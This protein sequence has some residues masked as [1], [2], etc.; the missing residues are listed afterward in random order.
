MGKQSTR[1]NKTIYQLC[2]EA[3]GLTRDQAAEKMK[4]LSV[5]R[6]EK[7]EYE[8]TVPD[9]YDVVE[10]A[11][12]YKRPDLCNYYCSHCCQIGVSHVP[13]VEISELPTIILKTIAA[14]NEINPQI[15]R[16]IQITQDGK[17]S[18]DEIKD[19]ALIT[20]RLNQVSMAVD[21][22]NLWVE[23]TAADNDLNI[24]LLNEETK[25]LL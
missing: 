12:C 9:P 20:H 17:I 22:L 10:M 16:L 5:S 1:E 21:A 18:D 11:A 2:R 15:T 7:I 25:K 4:T 23:K 6:I 24:E 3:A 8:L 19:F 14:L 13:E